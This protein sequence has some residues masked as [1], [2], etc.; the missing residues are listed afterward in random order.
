MKKQVFSIIG[1]SLVLFMSA[2]NTGTDQSM[3]MEQS[4]EVR[5]Q[6]NPNRHYDN[7]SN[8]DIN[9]DLGY[10]RYSKTEMDMQKPSN[11]EAKINRSEMA[12]MITRLIL[13][14]KG[15]EEVATLVTDQEVL[16]AFEKDEDRDSGETKEIARKTAE[17]VMPRFYD[18]YV[19]DNKSFM[20]DIQSLHNSDT[21][22]D[23]DQ[24][25]NQ[26]IDDM[27]N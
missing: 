3:E 22:R 15:F 1:I 8:Q 6:L 5:D 13:A 9:H 14:N 4:E 11:H 19:T 27:E 2:C 18:I 12:E 10:V 20:Q 23:Y 16:I 25:I 24:L 7:Q 21:N 17:S 26:L